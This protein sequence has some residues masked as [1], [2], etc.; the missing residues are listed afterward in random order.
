M[1]YFRLPAYTDLANATITDYVVRVHETGNYL[2][3]APAGLI[4]HPQAYDFFVQT[5]A[6]VNLDHFIEFYDG[7]NGIIDV[8]FR[9]PSYVT[10][11]PYDYRFKLGSRT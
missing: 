3:Q 6:G 10:N 5:A 1:I 4:T 7:V 8:A 9:I 2:K 11:S